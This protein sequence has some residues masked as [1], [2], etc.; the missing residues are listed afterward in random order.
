MFRGMTWA[1]L[2]VAMGL[3]LTGCGPAEKNRDTLT[4]S[5]DDVFGKDWAGRE[6][7]TWR[8][9]IDLGGA[10][11][12]YSQLG[13]YPIGNGRVFA[14]CGLTVPLGTASDCF[15]PSYQKTKG[16]MGSYMP[17][18]LVDG[19]AVTPPAQ[20]TAW[21]APGGVVH[22]RWQNNSGL[23]V[24]MLHT[25]P[26]DVDAIVRVIVVSNNGGSAIGDLA[27]GQS[28]SLVALEDED[29]D[30]LGERGA[31]VR[32][33]FAGARTQVVALDPTT[34][35]PQG[36]GDRLQPLGRRGE[37]LEPPMM[38]RCS[39]GRLE[40]GQSVGKVAWVTFA[41][42][43][44][45]ES[46]MIA[47]IEAQGLELFDAAH[48]WWQEWS[49]STVTVEGVEDQLAE[50]LTAGKYLCRVQQAEAGGYSPMHKYSYRWIRDSNGPVMHLL[51]VGDF[52]SVKRDLQY[53]YMASCKRGEVGNNVPLNMPLEEPPAVDWAEAPTPKAEIASF[54][55]LQNHWYWMHTG[56]TAQIVERWDYLKACLSGQAVDPEGRLPFHGDETYRF[57]GYNLES[58]GDTDSVADYVHLH[59]RSADSAFEYVAAAEA[60]A[61]MAKAIGKD[62]EVAGFRETA[63]TV[64]R[65]TEKYYWQDGRG[66]Y[67]PAMSEVSGEVYRYPFANI[68]MRPIWIGYAD[69]TARR[70]RENVLNALKWLYRPKSHT[71]NLTP[72]CGYTVGMTPGM[73]LSA[74]TSIDHPAAASIVDGVMISAEPSGGYAEMNR[75]DDLPSRDVWGLHRV[76]PWE[77]GIN[78]S[79][80]L[81][82]LTGFEP[83]APARTASFAP[84]LPDGCNSMTVTNLRVA[85]AR[86]ALTISRAGDTVTATV[87]CEQAKA[88]IEVKLVVAALGER[89]RREGSATATLDLSGTNSVEASVT[90]GPP[91]R[92][93]PTELEVAETPFDYG[94]AD[95][96]RGSTVLLTWSADVAK[97]VRKVEER[98]KVIDTRIAWPASYLRSAL[99]TENGSTRV[100]K[101]ITDVAGF[102]GGFKPNDYW[103]D[104]DGAGVLSEFRAAG[105]TVETAGVAGAGKTPSEELIN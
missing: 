53:H 62:D 57:P 3:A 36:L 1:M 23:Q 92:R 26:P 47:A 56:E 69:P 63:A 104:G 88:P 82:F 11:P 89:R 20:T 18:V 52:E 24:D 97:Q 74:L 25:V 42:D 93:V 86:M 83:N 35:L 22:T 68:N 5:Y 84:H 46:E 38:V 71:A 43:E 50:F 15:G 67:A 49:D 45:R 34:S 41:D 103:T 96:R 10:P 101:V 80:V 81:Q 21:V 78:Y 75:P 95:V 33:G 58:A 54:V 70:Q 27:L 39:L 55:V 28:T 9:E 31:R 40:S 72:T 29:G 7:E 61:E 19:E 37:G 13:A 64:R 59:L 8:T 44:A 17:V 65:A 102:A 73:V 87:R 77:G 16:M 90:A 51:D 105:G 94:R 32:L 85:E 100:E 48:Q 91:L 14:V 30:L 2:A 60:M 99:L 12:N 6:L 79:A 98:V 4:Y 66:Y 76:R